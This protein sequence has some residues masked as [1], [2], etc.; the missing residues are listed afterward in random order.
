MTIDLF[1]AHAASSLV[2]L[3]AAVATKRSVKPP[4]VMT[5][6]GLIRR[7]SI[8]ARRLSAVISRAK[9]QRLSSA[10]IIS[11]I[12]WK[13]SSKTRREDVVERVAGL[14][15]SIAP[16]VDSELIEVAT[17]EATRVF[18]ESAKMTMKSIEQ[19]ADFEEILQERS[20]VIS[21]LSAASLLF[22]GKRLSAKADSFARSSK[23]IVNNRVLRGE[24]NKKITRVLIKELDKSIMDK[25][26]WETVAL[27][28]V[29]RIRAFGILSVLS[30]VGIQ[31]YR[32]QAVLDDNTT[33]V[34]L[35]L[36][37]TEI[38][39]DSAIEVVT[40]LSESISM[41]EVVSSS[42][43]LKVIGD[44]LALPN[45]KTIGEVNEKSLIA[46]GVAL[47]PYHHRCRTSIEPVKE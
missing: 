12:N 19:V 3:I 28:L 14:M 35:A 24:R 1:G 18:T 7:T 8:T 15:E 46:S 23:R 34:C 20:R 21:G 4:T 47:P 10:R 17:R 39:V 9:D 29:S 38:S 16:E 32:I 26:Y 33:D 5:K 6:D 2:S 31:K 11:E 45:G 30:A 13:G 25:S 40:E 43:F 36:N 22:V 42:P 41:S 37:G 44:D 27:N